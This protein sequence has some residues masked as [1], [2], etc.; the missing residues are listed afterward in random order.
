[1]P[2]RIIPIFLSICLLC[3]C[4]RA[5]DK[6]SPSIKIDNIKISAN[7][8][9]DAFQNSSFAASDTPESRK[10]FLDTFISRMLILRQAQRTGMDKDPEFLKSV[11]R[12]WQQSLV[13]MVLDKKIKELSSHVRVDDTEVKSYYQ[14]NKNSEFAGQELSVVYDKIKWTI[15]NKKQQALLNDWLDSLRVNT[16]IDMDTKFLQGKK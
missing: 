8:Y 6:K 13:K 5:T 1:M 3:G 10:E 12:F 11:E 4:G 16:K 14:A 15:L 2:S 7:D 9:E